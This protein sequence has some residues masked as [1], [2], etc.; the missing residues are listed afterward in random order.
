M[1]ERNIDPLPSCGSGIICTGSWVKSTTKAYALRG[2]KLATFWLWDD[3]PTESHEPG[4]S[5]SNTITLYLISYTLC[6][7]PLDIPGISEPACFLLFFMP[8]H[9]LKYLSGIP[10]LDYC[11]DCWKN[12]KGFGQRKNSIFGQK[13]LLLNLPP[14]KLQLKIMGHRYPCSLTIGIWY[15][16]GP[17]R[18]RKWKQL[19]D[20]C[21]SVTHPRR[22]ENHWGN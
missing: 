4:R 3:T 17:A 22:L 1:W 10:L 11:L 2:I 16:R 9:G 19:W 8:L 7:C 18:K 14:L 5:F 6:C 21:P 15:P 13:K 20:L 12:Y